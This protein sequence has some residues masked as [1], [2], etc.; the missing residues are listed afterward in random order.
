[1]RRKLASLFTG[2]LMV[3]AVMFGTA[4]TPGSADAA[5]VKRLIFASAGFHESNRFW[6]IA[7]PDHLQF[8][9]FWETLVGMDP[10]TGDPIPQLATKWEHSPDFKD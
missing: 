5:Q 8:E 7:R 6:T 3:V 10:K 2:L 9:P 4:V 1:M